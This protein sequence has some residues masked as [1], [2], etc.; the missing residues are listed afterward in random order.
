MMAYVGIMAEGTHRDIVESRCCLLGARDAF[1]A[2]TRCADVNY[3]LLN[4]LCVHALLQFATIT[5]SH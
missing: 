3:Y 5:D 1:N 2:H 4:L